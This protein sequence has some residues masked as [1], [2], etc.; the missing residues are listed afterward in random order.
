VSLGSASFLVDSDRWRLPAI[1]TVGAWLIVRAGHW[2]ARRRAG[3]SGP[4]FG[5]SGTF[6]AFARVVTAGAAIAAVVAAALCGSAA[7]I[8]AAFTARP[9]VDTAVQGAKFGAILGVAAMVL[10]LLQAVGAAALDRWFPRHTE[11]EWIAIPAAVATAREMCALLGGATVALAVV[12]VAE[13]TPMTVG[14]AVSGVVTTV[15][16]VTR[17]RAATAAGPGARRFRK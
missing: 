9:V 17:L 7:A 14:T 5:R 13:G 4:P 6:R 12:A 1:A 10:V 3:V 11:V 8:G 2:V 16:A 15:Y